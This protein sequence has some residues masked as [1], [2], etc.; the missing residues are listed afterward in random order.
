MVVRVI[1]F[2]QRLSFFRL[3][4][5]ATRCQE[6]TEPMRHGD[7]G[8]HTIRM[9]R[10]KP[11]GNQGIYRDQGPL[12]CRRQGYLDTTKYSLLLNGSP[13]EELAHCDPCVAEHYSM[14]I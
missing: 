3:D 8:K 10:M 1:E 13:V 7:T 9:A 11:R 5:T 12:L 6:L 2:P 4:I 14:I